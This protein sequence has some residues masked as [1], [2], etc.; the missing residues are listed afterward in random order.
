M[1]DHHGDPTE[2]AVET[3]QAEEAEGRFDRPDQVG[4]RGNQDVEEH[5]VERG[6][7][8]IDRISGN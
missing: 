5:D 2:H 1:T 4:V 3:P 8:K 6:R 7:E